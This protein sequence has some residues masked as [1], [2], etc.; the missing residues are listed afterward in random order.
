M[1][2]VYE[3]QWKWQAY[4]YDPEED[5][6]EMDDDATSQYYHGVDFQ[7]NTAFQLGRWHLAWNSPRKELRN[8]RSQLVLIVRIGGLSLS[9]IYAQT[10]NTGS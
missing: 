9:T 3:S 5:V 10:Y 4:G 7:T 6:D 2:Q 1:G 8:C